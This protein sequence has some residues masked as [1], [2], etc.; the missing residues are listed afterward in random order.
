MKKFSVKS[1][2]ASAILA[3]LVFVLIRFVSIPT[4]LPNTTLSVYAAVSAFFACLFGPAVGFLGTFIGDL[5]VDVTAGWGIWWTWIIPTGLYGLIMGIGCKGINLEDGEFG[6]K[7]MIRFIVVSFIGCVICWGILAPLGDVIFYAE[8]AGKVIGQG[9][10]IGLSGF[11][12]TAVIG[13]ILCKAYA[14]TKAKKGS[15]KKED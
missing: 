13:T 5:M 9:A 1:V 6:K 7:E 11:I 2:V 14:A 8:P 10:C 15:L 3:A 4:P 12:S